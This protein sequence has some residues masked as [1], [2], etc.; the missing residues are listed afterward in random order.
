MSALQANRYKHGGSQLKQNDQGK[1]LI[2]ADHFFFININHLI[3]A[4]K[5]IIYLR[6]YKV[7]DS[8]LYCGCKP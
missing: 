2:G 5:P 6:G 1:Q 4:V 8:C 3:S 7:S